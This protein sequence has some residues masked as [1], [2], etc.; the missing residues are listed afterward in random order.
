[1]KRYS[2]L[3]FLFLF[4]WLCGQAQTSK[5]MNDLNFN[6]DRNI[7][8]MKDPRNEF[9][10][11]ESYLING[12]NVVGSPFLYD[13]WLS[14]KIVTADGRQYENYKLKYDAYHQTLH[15]QEGANSLEVNEAVKNFSIRFLYE[16]SVSEYTFDYYPKAEKQDKPVFLEILNEGSR[17]TLYKLNKKITINLSKA[18]PNTM[19]TEQFDLKTLY[20]ILDKQNNKL[21]LVKGD[22]SNIEEFMKLKFNAVPGVLEQMAVD[23]EDGLMLYVNF[24]NQK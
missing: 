13:L 19:A 23:I 9:L 17:A 24:L 12:K 14:G 7:R 11:S 2:G 1:M 8:S 20:Y 16:G 3:F 21:K 6:M 18:I 15:F 5:I 4:T 10:Y 22:G